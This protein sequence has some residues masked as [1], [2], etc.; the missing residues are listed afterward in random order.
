MKLKHG[1]ALAL[2]TIML[3]SV[4]VLRESSALARDDED[5]AAKL[6]DLLKTRRETLRQLLKVAEE[7]YRTGHSSFDSVVRASDQLIK[8]ELELAEGYEATLAL[9]EQRVGQFQTLENMATA[10]YQAGQASQEDV[11]AA[12]AGRLGAEIELL[13]AQGMER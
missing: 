11:L 3:L 12:R 13:R 9:Y 5:N 1:T 8:A 2:V 6:T 10:R 4:G 7:Q